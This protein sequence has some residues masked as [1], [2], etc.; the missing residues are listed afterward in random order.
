MEN[1]LGKK[2]TFFSLIKDTF[3]SIIMMV[4]FSMYTIVDGAFISAF[5]GPNGLSATNIVYPVVNIIIGIG[6]MMATGG[7]AIIAR[8]MGE[9]KED[10]AREGFSFIIAVVIILGTGIGMLGIIFINP[11]IKVLG[12]TDLLYEYCY[13]YLIVNLMF[14]PAIILKMFFDYF[15]ITAGAPKL[16]LIS[17][18]MGGITNMIL[19]YVFVA[20]LNMGI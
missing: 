6:I 20:L 11:I 4:F 5:V 13:T 9:K 2:I 1:T 12:S 17:S 8:Y 14:S 3:P 10:K 16:G 7:S 18:V 19:D 15:L